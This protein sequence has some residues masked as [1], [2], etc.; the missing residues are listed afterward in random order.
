MSM[1]KGSRDVERW[2]RTDVAGCSLVSSI[3]NA[4]GPLYADTMWGSGI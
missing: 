4:E 3:I 1:G 2:E